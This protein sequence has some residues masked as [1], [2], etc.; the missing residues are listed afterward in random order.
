MLCGYGLL[1]E[2]E[3]GGMMRAGKQNKK[4]SFQ[5]GI[6]LL[7]ILAVPFLNVASVCAAEPLRD[8]N[9]AVEVNLTGGSG[10]AAIE[11][12]ALMEVREGKYYAWIVWSSSNYDYMIVDG[13]R[14]E[15]EAG[16]NEHSSFLIPVL[17]FDEDVEVIADTLAM[18]EPHEITY[19]LRFYADSI[20]DESALPREGAKRVLMMAAFIIIAGGVLNYYTNKKRKRDYL[21]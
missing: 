5:V 10:K 15:N 9:Y 20:A 1:E 17:A 18:G 21:G 16:E 12:P 11:S 2:M 4:K 7:A 19:I 14:Y 13:I 6:M 3:R 8:G